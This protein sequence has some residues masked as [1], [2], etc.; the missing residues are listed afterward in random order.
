MQ[1]RANT[2]ADLTGASDDHAVG[3]TS[4]V[5]ALL[6]SATSRAIRLVDRLAKVLSCGDASHLV[7]HDRPTSAG[8]QVFGFGPG[9]RGLFGHDDEHR[10][11]VLG[12]VLGKPEAVRRDRAPAASRSTL[13]RLVERLPC[14]LIE[15]VFKVRG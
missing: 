5:A 10:D 2:Q 8:Q 6:L 12:A 9:S 7:I 15:P 4:K 14:P 1:V 13:I 11:P 3:P